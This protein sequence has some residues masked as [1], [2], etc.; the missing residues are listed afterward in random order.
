MDKTLIN[1]GV[2]SECVTEVLRDVWGTSRPRPRPWAMGLRRDPSRREELRR[3]ARRILSE[4]S[5]LRDRV[6]GL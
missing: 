4:D 6:Y 1:A 2:L 5:R 3:E